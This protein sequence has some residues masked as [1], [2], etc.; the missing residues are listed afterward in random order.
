MAPAETV[1]K[2]KPAAAAVAEKKTTGTPTN[3]VPGVIF[4][5]AMKRALP[6]VSRPSQLLQATPSGSDLYAIPVSIVHVSAERTAVFAR[7]ITSKGILI[8][9]LTSIIPVTGTDLLRRR[10]GADPRNIY[11]SAL[12]VD[13]VPTGPV[14]NELLHV[15]LL[16]GTASG[17]GDDAWSTL[18]SNPT[19]LFRMPTAMLQ[20]CAG[21]DDAPPAAVSALSTVDEI[22]R[23]LAACHLRRHCT[24]QTQFYVRPPPTLKS[25]SLIAPFVSTLPTQ[26]LVGMDSGRVYREYAHLRSL[27]YLKDAATEG[28]VAVPLFRRVKSPDAQMHDT[29]TMTAFGF[30]IHALMDIHDENRANM[31]PMPAEFYAPGVGSCV[32]ADTD[33]VSPMQT[34]TIT[35]PLSLVIHLYVSLLA[36]LAEE[37]TA[38]FQQVDRANQSL[39]LLF[40]TE[41]PII[42]AF[43]HFTMTYR[44]VVIENH[45]F[46]RESVDLSEDVFSGRSD[47]AAG[48]W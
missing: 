23:A 2:K 32:V 43:A 3:A 41:G 12:D 15:A 9:Q 27:P 44:H 30:W 33:G 19:H 25:M 46:G 26:M 47:V 1:P 39:A 17:E 34:A 36:H 42:G 35:A 38:R 24:A 21:G 16:L 8:V 20:R 10:P 18:P 6:Q 48:A 13:I 45:M 40:K 4:L 7:T 22:H 28:C 37:A 31:L 11:I 5:L 29:F 14:K